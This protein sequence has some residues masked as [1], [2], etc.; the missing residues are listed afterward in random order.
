MF[1][2]QM[3][4]FIADIDQ[5]GKRLMIMYTHYIV[6]ACKMYGMN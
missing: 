4:S 6:H 5:L 3:F 1:W 2:P